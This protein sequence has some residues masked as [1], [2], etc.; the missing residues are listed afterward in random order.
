[1]KWI[2]ADERTPKQGQIVLVIGDYINELELVD[3]NKI[4][5]VSWGT[6]EDSYLFNQRYYA[7]WFTNITHWCEITEHPNQQ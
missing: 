7:E 1:M 3:Y 2:S 4:G 6:R 5:L